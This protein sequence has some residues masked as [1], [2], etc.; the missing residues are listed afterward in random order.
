MG[1]SGKIGTV[2]K[3]L[4]S[5]V[6][7]QTNDVSYIDTQGV[8]RVSSDD[9]ISQIP[10]MDL[11]GV[12]RPRG[13]EW[14]EDV[15]D[16]VSFGTS[17][18][19]RHFDGLGRG[20]H[21]EIL[22]KDESSEMSVFYKGHLVYREIQGDLVCYVPIPE[23]EDWVSSLFKL[24]KKVQRDEKEEEFKAKVQEAERNKD[25]WLRSIASRWGIT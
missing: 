14:S 1:A 4:G 11:D 17:C 16:A 3:A 9:L 23:W 10:V 2:L 18:L 22:Y 5:P 6:V 15:P 20:M 8:E 24:A 25:S 19:G 21:L 7:S 13:S 12:E